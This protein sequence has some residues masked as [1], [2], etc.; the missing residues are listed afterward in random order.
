MSV[1]NKCNFRIKQEP[2][3]VPTEIIIMMK[4]L[5]RGD[6]IDHLQASFGHIKL[7]KKLFKFYYRDL[8]SSNTH[9]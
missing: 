4:P 3:S 5:L 1:S 8:N 9:D 6:G 2:N 7:K